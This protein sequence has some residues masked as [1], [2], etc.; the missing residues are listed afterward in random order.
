M[1]YR[2]VYRNLMKVEKFSIGAERKTGRK[3]IAQYYSG[4]GPASQA[5]A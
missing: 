4:T 3:H 1:I 2:S 5:I